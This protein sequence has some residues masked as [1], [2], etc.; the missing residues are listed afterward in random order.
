MT[1][2]NI[3]GKGTHNVVFVATEH[4]S[5]YAFDA[6]DNSG[7]N[8]SA[9]WHT[10]FLGP[11]VTTVPSGDTGTTDIT[12]EVGIT[13]TP[14]IDPVSG[15]IYSEVKTKENGTTY[16]HRLHALDITTGLERTN[17]NSPVVIQCTITSAKATATMTA[18]TRHTCSGIRCASTAG[19][20]SRCSMALSMCLCLAWRQRRLIMA[21]FWLQRHQPRADNPASSTAPPTAAWAADSGT[22]AAALPWMRKA[23]CISRPAMA[24][25]SGHQTVTTSN[26]YAM[27]LIKF[28][29]TNG[30]QMVDFFAPSNA[31]NL[32]A[33]TRTSAPAR[34]LFCRIRPAARRILIWSWAAARPADLPGGPGQHGTLERHR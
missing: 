33:E 8:A 32:A 9:L 29:T 12:P 24:L 23:T 28:A 18:R 20:R 11:N 27:S 25:R 30:I 14:V 3:P 6:D 19:R 21:G 22:A 5:I 17:F 7:L 10:S 16:V 15:T 13:S 4:N 2:V 31:V 26:N 1:N 34:R